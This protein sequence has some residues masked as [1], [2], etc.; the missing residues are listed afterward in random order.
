MQNTTIVE[1]EMF[2]EIFKPR[3][4]KLFD[5]IKEHGGLPFFHCC[6]YMG[7][8]FDELVDLGIRG[9]WHQMNL[10][11]EDAVLEEKCKENKIAVFIHPDRQKLIPLGTPQEIR[12]YIKR[13]A[14][15]YKKMGGGGIF[16]VEIEDDAP[17][18]NVLALFEAIDQ[19]R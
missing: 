11:E 18:E 19:Y 14:E 6:G 12:S 7:E 5:R 15:K 8:I 10:Y 2:R 17:F 16:Y 9:L 3:Y 4:K 1:P 13:K